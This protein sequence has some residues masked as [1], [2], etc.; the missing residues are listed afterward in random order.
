M[1]DQN[2]FLR[3]TKGKGMWQMRERNGQEEKE[4]SE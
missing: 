1:D 4:N 3:N 2:S